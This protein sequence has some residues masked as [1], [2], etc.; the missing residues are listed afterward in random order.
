MGEHLL[1]C[2][3]QGLEIGTLNEM[4]LHFLLKDIRQIENNT[5]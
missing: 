3:V 5:V 1:V 4:L 2:A